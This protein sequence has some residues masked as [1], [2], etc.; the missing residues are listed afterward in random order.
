M[1]GIR[2]SSQI[3]QNYTAT[4]I[5]G[6]YFMLDAGTGGQSDGLVAHVEGGVHGHILR[7]KAHLGK[8]VAQNIHLLL[9]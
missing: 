3:K 7:I 8:G 9:D 5:G 2:I 6:G 1:Q 4:V